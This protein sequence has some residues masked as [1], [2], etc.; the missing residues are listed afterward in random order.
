MK[1]HHPQRDALVTGSRVWEMGHV[2]RGTLATQRNGT[3]HGLKLIWRSI[4]SEVSTLVH[5]KIVTELL[6]R[7]AI[8][9][10]TYAITIQAPTIYP[11]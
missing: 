5:K 3:L 1:K 4:C 10:L 9:T 8:C 11:Q 6:H 7:N 2:A